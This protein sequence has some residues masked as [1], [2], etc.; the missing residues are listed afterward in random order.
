MNFF[1]FLVSFS[2]DTLTLKDHIQNKNA[3]FY[4]SLKC[5]ILNAHLG[6]LFL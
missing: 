2:S 4:I 6:G 3:H 1:F 5:K